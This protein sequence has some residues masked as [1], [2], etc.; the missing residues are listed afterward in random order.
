[1]DDATREELLAENE[2]LRE[3]VQIL[4]DALTEAVGVCARWSIPGYRA[5]QVQS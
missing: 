5:S 4:T 3:Q 1:M 2:K